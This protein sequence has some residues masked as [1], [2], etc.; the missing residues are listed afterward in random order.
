VVYPVHPNPNVWEPVHNAL[1]G[2]PNVLLLPPLDYQRLVYLM[3]GSTLILTD[4]G[5]IQEEAPALGK[6]VMVLRQVT[7]RPEGVDAGTAVL[8]GTEP[9]RIVTQAS[10][11]LDDPAAYAEMAHSVNPYGDGRA[12]ERIVAVLLEWDRGILAT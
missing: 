11:L 3:K 2:T 5:G 6:P 1:E 8:V 12:A 7:E 4:S 10:R 9:G